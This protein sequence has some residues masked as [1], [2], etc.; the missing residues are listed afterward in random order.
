[1]PETGASG[2]MRTETHNQ[3]WLCGLNLFIVFKRSDIYKPNDLL[4]TLKQEAGKV[5]TEWHA[6]QPTLDENQ[7]TQVY[8]KKVITK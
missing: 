7:K 2:Y 1:M 8:F 4:L 6:I 3:A 5:T